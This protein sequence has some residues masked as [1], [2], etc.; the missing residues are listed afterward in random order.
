[1]TRK[2]ILDITTTKKRDQM[3]SYSNARGPNGT[4]PEPANS[5]GTDSGS[6]NLIAAPALIRGN[7]GV[8]F[9]PWI[10]TARNINPTVDLPTSR[11]RETVYMRGLKE[12]IRVET[13]SGASF[14][15]R[16]I[17]FT[18][19][20]SLL[21]AS[22][23]GGALWDINR[24][25]IGAG[26]NVSLISATARTVFD[27][28]LFK[29]TFGKDYRN[30]MDAIVDRQTVNVK[31]DK[32]FNIRSGNGSGVC[33]TYNIWHPMN[34]N[35]V[36]DDDESG[37]G[38]IGNLLSTNSKQGMG[39]YYIVDIIQGVSAATADDIMVFDPTAT[40]YWHEK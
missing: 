7:G 8:Y 16:R 17:A 25:D 23:N 26:R 35:L 9:F 37:D 3:M 4:T 24:P 13:N 5:G 32:I 36:Y 30:Y 14:R 12:R 31:M 29:G 40:L 34:S 28:T 2:R 15:W 27:R 1:M 11:N 19:K 33:K 38:I 10:A 20:G 21:W 18:Q 39:D 22:T 6:V